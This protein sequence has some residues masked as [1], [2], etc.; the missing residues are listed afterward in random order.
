[1]E[2][3]N[4]LVLALTPIVV[5]VVQALKALRIPDSVAPVLSLV[6]G[7]VAGA[8][9]SEAGTAW[10]EMTLTGIVIGLSASGLYSGVVST[11]SAIA[12]RSH[13]RR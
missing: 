13:V 10:Q 3:D 7:V 4:T 12:I 9:W 6:L 5:G 11:R 2:V 1:M 8:L